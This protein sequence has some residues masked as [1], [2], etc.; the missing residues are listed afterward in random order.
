M[1]IP[2]RLALS[3]CTVVAL[4]ASAVGSSG[5]P[6]R[7]FLTEAFGL[8]A[9][10]ISRV[11]SGEV[12]TRTLDASNSREIATLGVVRIRTTPEV[13]VERLNDIATF[14]LTDDVLQ[15][16]KFGS[17]AVS[18][19]VAPMMLDEADLKQLR[20][21]EVGDCGVR[22]S[23]GDIERVRREIDWRAPDASRR[24]SALVQQV[25]VDYVG[26]YRANG[27]AGTMEYATTSAPLHVGKEFAA[28]VAAD[29]T[30]WKF[31][32]R[33][34]R[35]LLEYPAAID[36][37]A[38]DFVYWSKERVHRRLVISLTHVAILPAVGESPVNFAIAS[39]QIYAMHYFDA[40][41]GLTLLV[42]DLTAPA[43]TPATYVVYLNRS[44]IDLFEG[45]LGGVTR[46]IVV[47][48]A[49]GLVAEQLGRLQRTLGGAGTST[50]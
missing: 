18:G 7:A 24:A 44:R 46:R 41:L 11:D 17:P 12:V 36:D 38:S 4:A 30:T 9:A 37:S 21:C 10:D 5:D 3:M 20:D 19:D 2:M 28:L 15:V 32:P 35:H 33:L 39:K 49:R 26:R 45:L 50:R 8:S 14:K 25:L 23:A 31:V 16:G 27:S 48:K 22:L 42:R 13:Y 40:S 29:T 43:L 1:V 6:A 47:G 34:R